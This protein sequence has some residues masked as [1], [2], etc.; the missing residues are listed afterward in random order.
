MA[1]IAEHLAK[2][3]SNGVWGAKDVNFRAEKSRITVLL[4]PNGA[5]KTTTVGM[6]TT[7]LRPIKGRAIIEG[8]ITTKDV[9]KVREIIA[10][11]P[12]DI[13]V[14]NNWSPLDALKGYLMI[15]GFSKEDVVG[16]SEKYL[17]LLD[18]WD[19]RNTP[20]IALSGGQRKRIA[21]AMV[22]AS[23]APVVFLDEPSSG[24]DVEARYIVWKSL[25]EEA[26]RGKT[27]ILTTHDMKEAEILGDYIVMISKGRSVAKGTTEELKKRIPYTH[28]IVVKNA[29]KLP[30]KEHID[31]GDR[32]IIYAGSREEAMEI[33]EKIEAK[34][35]GIEEVTLEDSYLYIVGGVANGEN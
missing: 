22:L 8:Y 18:L 4:G 10:L 31:L 2:K 33:A 29:L 12:Q 34:S 28:K 17:K 27:I 30:L 7:L 1:V 5:G 20:A 19:V 35:I 3:Y 6:L 14:D 24:L 21:V 13:R 26:N 16:R 9:W 15:R 11:C 23:D 32:K 25:R